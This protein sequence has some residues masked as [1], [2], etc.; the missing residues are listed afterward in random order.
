MDKQAQ[1]TQS[2][3]PVGSAVRL[4]R[5]ALKASLATLDKGHP[6]ASLVLVATDPDGAPILLISRLAQHTRNLE[7]DPRACLLFDGTD[8]AQDPL[9]GP[10]VSVRGT[11]HVTREPRA[12]RRFLARHPAA[13]GYAA[14]PDFQTC[15]MQVNSAHFVGGFGRIVDVAGPDLLLASDGAEA[16]LQAESEIIAHMNDDHAD[17]VR[18]YA[19]RLC[20][21]PDGDWRMTGVDPAGFDLLCGAR[22]LRVAFPAA[23]TSP[24]DARRAFVAMAQTARTRGP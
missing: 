16:L 23:V 22:G 14:F 17:A 21:A 9:S 4:I 15:R 19:T 2:E 24:A 13:Q 7:A 11:V 18:L 3:T 5:T 20:G 1:T 6:Y 8:A 10:R 12:L